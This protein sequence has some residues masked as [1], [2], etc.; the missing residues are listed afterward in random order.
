MGENLFV[1][2][3]LVAMVPLCGI[4]LAVT[5]WLMRKGECFAVSVPESAR[6]DNRLRSMKRSYLIVMLAITALCTVAAVAACGVL[7]ENPVL[8]TTLY[9]AAVIVPEAAGFALMLFF[10]SKVQQIKFDESWVSPHAVQI[11]S[12]VIGEEEAEAPQA[13]SLLW[14]L[15]YLPII[16]ACVVVPLLGYDQLPDQ[17]PMHAGFNGEVDSCAEKSFLTLMFPAFLNAF[18]AVCFVFSHLTIKISK[19]HREPGAPRTSE[20]A[21]GMFARAQSIFLLACGLLMC[22]GMGASLILTYFGKISLMGACVII[23]GIAAIVLVG[24]IAISVV[25]GQ[26]GSRLFS[27]MQD[28]DIL[29]CDDDRYWKLGVFYVNPDDPSLFLPQ[30]FGVGWTCNFGRKGTWLIIAG[31]AVFTLAFLFACFRLF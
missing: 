5:P 14:N 21:Y 3:V 29:L 15:L 23:L 7:E 4:L 26:A 30:R 1:T 18:L 27:R 25:Y 6:N 12:A 2:G 13:I 22:A 16:A 17:I 11:R 9:L 10:R 20:Y 31:F 24:A 8:F 19:K 28:Q